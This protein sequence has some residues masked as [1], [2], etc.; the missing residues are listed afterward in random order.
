MEFVQRYFIPNRT[1][2]LGDIA[3]DGI[4]SFGGM[5][6]SYFRYIKK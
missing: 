3:A 6:W 4:G 1:F 2:D 5:L